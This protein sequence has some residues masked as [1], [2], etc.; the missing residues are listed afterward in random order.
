MM[1]SVLLALFFLFR[2][3]TSCINRREYDEECDMQECRT[4]QNKE[5][6][7]TLRYS[8]S[9]ASSDNGNVLCI[10][11]EKF[12]KNI[13][14]VHISHTKKYTWVYNAINVRRFIGRQWSN[15]HDFDKPANLHVSWSSQE[16]GLIYICMV[17]KDMTTASNII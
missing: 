17:L 12:V 11:I 15:R 3:T 9:S 7:A 2:E 4:W 10:K 14:M 13:A 16:A 1:F 8:N 6:C 5:V